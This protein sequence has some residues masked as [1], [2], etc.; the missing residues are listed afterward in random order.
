MNVGLT[1]CL[2]LGL[3]QKHKLP[4]A[5]SR[6]KGSVFLGLWEVISKINIFCLTHYIKQ[7][8]KHTI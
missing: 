8:V 3:C 6:Q 5:R 7:A 2:L 1:S 4:T